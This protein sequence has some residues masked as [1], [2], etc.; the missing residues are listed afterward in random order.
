MPL[1]ALP[2]LLLLQTPVTARLRSMLVL[3]VTMSAPSEPSAPGM[4]RGCANEDGATAARVRATSAW[5]FW[6]VGCVFINFDLGHSGLDTC[7]T[8]I[9]FHGLFRDSFRTDSRPVSR[10]EKSLWIKAGAGIHKLRNPERRGVGHEGEPVQQV[11]GRLDDE[12]LV[13]RPGQAKAGLAVGLIDGPIQV[14]GRIIDAV[15]ADDG[16]AAGGRAPV[17]GDHDVIAARLARLQVGEE[18]RRVGG[19]AEVASIAPP[20]VAQRR[21]A[22]GR[23]GERD[24]G[25]GN[26]V[27]AGRLLRDGRWHY[28]IERGQGAGGRAK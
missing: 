10:P 27:R 13:G 14:H 7:K 17:V 15:H 2:A 21:R 3:A 19:A 28:H 23:D 22:G 12:V 26:G 18:K 8:A 6:T 4:V 20:L 25:A 24:G 5:S 11:G 1:P 9:L 16:H